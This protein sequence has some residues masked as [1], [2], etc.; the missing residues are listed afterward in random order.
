VS[1]TETTKQAMAFIRKVAGLPLE[2]EDRERGKKHWDPYDA[3][4]EL[5]HLIST[6]RDVVKPEMVPVSELDS[7]HVLMGESGGLSAV[8]AAK[9]S[10]AMPGCMRVETEHGSLY[11]DEDATVEVLA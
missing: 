6:A 2:G 3:L 9:P 1:S 4:D 5:H 10:S 8:Y 7:S 11:V